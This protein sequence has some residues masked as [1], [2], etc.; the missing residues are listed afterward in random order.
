MTANQIVKFEYKNFGNKANLIRRYTCKNSRQGH[1]V[2]W[3]YISRLG[4]VVVVLFGERL[5]VHGFY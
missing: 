4:E 3:V 1:L 5:K 2:L